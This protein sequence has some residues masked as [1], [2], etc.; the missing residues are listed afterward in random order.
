MWKLNKLA[1]KKG[2]SQQRNQRRNQKN[3]LII[4][5]N[6]NK[7]IQNLWNATKRVLSGKITGLPQ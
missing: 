6:K 5:E 4:N 1:T 2:L 7:T 3:I